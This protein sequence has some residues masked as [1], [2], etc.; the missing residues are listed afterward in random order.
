[1]INL[2]TVVFKQELTYLKTQAKSIELY[3]NSSDINSIVVVV[4]D[5]IDVLN[6][7]DT[8][9]YGINSYK[10]KLIHYS[11]LISESELLLWASRDGWET[12]QICK[13]LAS[14]TSTVD[15]N[16]IIDAKTFF[17]CPLILSNIINSDNQV[18]SNP[19]KI[20]HY[21]TNERDFIEEYFNIQLNNNYIGPGGV[22]FLM[23]TPTVK[24]MIDYI[25]IRENI[26]LTEFF[27]QHPMTEFLLYSGYVMYINKDY[28][29]LYQPRYMNTYKYY[30]IADWQ[31]EEFDSIMQFIN[32]FTNTL[33]ISLHRRAYPHLTDA[34]KTKWFELLYNKGLI[35]SVEDTKDEL[36][37]VLVP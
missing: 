1:M 34:Q 6:S 3:I 35:D 21:F 18:F 30:H 26:S 16:M 14:N 31:Y 9:W 11:E 17:V 32:K 25:K 2:V 23:H 33:T 15:W 24:S 36:N 10:V 13:L 12:Q 28:T 7:I 8:T 4:N 5:S 29:T 37:T 20:S 27:S 22:P 19:T